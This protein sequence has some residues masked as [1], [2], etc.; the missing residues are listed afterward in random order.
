MRTPLV[1]ATVAALSGCGTD[2]TP[3]F[4]QSVNVIALLP[5]TGTFANKGPEHQ[6]AIQMA[7]RDLETAGGVDDRPLQLVVIDS[8]SDPEIAAARLDAQIE[9]LTVDGELHVAGIISSTTAALKGAAPIALDLG[10]PHIEVSSG[11]GLDELGLTGVDASY[12][13]A[14][15]PLCMPEPEITAEFVAARDGQAGWQRIVVLRGT[16]GHDLMHTGMFREALVVEGFTGM[17]LNEQDIEMESGVPYETYFEDH[18]MPMQADVV[19]YHLN[20]DGP[21][22][23]FILAAERA[24]FQGKIITCGMARKTDLLDPVEPGVADYMSAGSATEGRF[25]FAMRGPTDTTAR[26]AFDADFLAYSGYDAETFSPAAYDAMTLLGLAVADAGTGTDQAAIR[27]A[28]VRVSAEGDPFGYGQLR[29]ALSRVRSGGDVDYDGV[30]SDLDLRLDPVLGYLTVGRFYIE[31]VIQL[32]G[33]W[34]YD[35]L[36]SPDEER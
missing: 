29:Q 34:E 23:D 4:D 3:S 9:E 2:P 7:I 6:A 22:R 8:T 17:V 36:P 13:F 30:S 12:E 26:D 11:S 24:G 31:T 25:F 14:T 16:Q 15:R 5:M 27:D 18:V 32:E 21:N 28:L 10:I 35:A 20:G 33:R 1:A 19:Y